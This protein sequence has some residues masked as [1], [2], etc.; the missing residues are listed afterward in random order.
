MPMLK[1]LWTLA[2][3]PVPRAIGITFFVSG[4]TFG[5]WASCIPYVKEKFS[6]DDAE[7]GLLLLC[8]PVGG[9]VMNSLVALA[10]KRLGINRSVLIFGSFLGIAFALPVI[11]PALLLVGLALFISGSA[12][13]CHNVAM[14]TY[15]SNLEVNHR[16]R[17]MSTCHGMWSLGA[18]L[19]AFM[20]SLSFGILSHTF[21]FADPQVLY[22]LFVAIAMLILVQLTK[23]SLITI[24]E[25]VHEEGEKVKSRS[26]IKPHGTL[27]LLASILVCT[28]F[29][30]GT[31]ADWSAVYMADIIAAPPTLIGWGFGM[32]AC[33]QAIGR[34]VGDELIHRFTNMIVLRI[35]GV[36]VIVGMI[37]VMLS[38][39]P[40]FVLPGFMLIGFGN[41][42]A[43]PILYAAA[44]RVPGLAPG[45]GLGTMNSFGMVAF[46]TGPVIVGFVSKLIDLRFAFLLVIL[47]AIIWIIQTSRVIRKKVSL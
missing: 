4:F 24:P 34:F 11:A 37:W 3:Q 20:S 15:A 46:L 43:S 30:E 36:L 18:M 38:V 23:R 31:M 14:N 9:L 16:M 17:L 2:R 12:F 47:M 28:Y 29:T 26:L 8:M 45:V 5:S 7:L 10:M 19:G 1:H 33:C 41:A 6:L 13:A 27:L 42:L 22:F 21:S 39:S 44:A 25:Q 32:Y 35:G 40:W